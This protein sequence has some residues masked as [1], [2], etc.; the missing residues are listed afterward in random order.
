MQLLYIVGPYYD[1]DRIHGIDRNVNRASA[2]ALEAWRLGWAVICPQK[3]RYPFHYA[4]ISCSVWHKGGIEIMLRCDAI[5]LIPGWFH[6]AAA[7]IEYNAALA[8]GLGVFDYSDNGV[9]LPAEVLR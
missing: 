7:R 2:I 1:P 6:S 4:N 5:L 3:N 8:N 9:P